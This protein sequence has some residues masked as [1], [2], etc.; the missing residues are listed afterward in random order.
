MKLPN[1]I[2]FIFNFFLEEG[3][4]LPGLG[5][6]VMSNCT[7]PRIL[8]LK[9]PAPSLGESL[10]APWGTLYIIRCNTNVQIDF[11]IRDTSTGIQVGIKKGNLSI[12]FL[13]SDILCTTP[14]P[15][16]L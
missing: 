13:S 14:F 4:P 6:Q 11:L 7:N 12:P 9:N 5:L 10:T 1:K 2:T 15:Q 3:T 8:L 16:V